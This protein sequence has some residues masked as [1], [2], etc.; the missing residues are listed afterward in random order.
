MRIASL[1]ALPAL[2]A[3][4][5]ATSTPQG[6]G[7]PEGNAN[8]TLPGDTTDDAGASGNG[9]QAG[10]GA[11]GGHASDGAASSSDAGAE[12]SGGDSGTTRPAGP[13]PWAASPCTG[14]AIGTNDILSHFAPAATS[15]TFGTVWVDAQQRQCQ[16]Q[17]G[18]QGWQ[19]ASSFD[20]YRI[21]YTGSGFTFTNPTTIPVPS[22][23]TITCTVP[24]P[25]CTLTIGAMTSNVYPAEQGRPLGITP[26]IAG[27]QVQVGNWSFDTRGNYL[28]YTSSTVTTTC[29][30]GSMSGRVYGASGTYVE[31]QMVV[32]GSF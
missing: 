11:D 18:C 10:P 26:R 15:A 24:G 17:T 14:A 9:S 21:A 7:G 30:W 2:L 20:L 22:S 31:T 29:L 12:A 4:A 28:Q 5:C 8:G 32:W 23:G 27:A 19:P 25:S 3:V 1:F 6:F 13:T 16:D